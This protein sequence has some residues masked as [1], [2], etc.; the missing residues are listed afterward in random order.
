[1]SDA[2]SAPDCEHCGRTG[3]YPDACPTWSEAANTAPDEESAP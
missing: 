3:H 2:Y 1:M